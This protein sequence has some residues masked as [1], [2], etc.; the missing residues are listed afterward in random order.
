MEYLD[1]RKNKVSS[2]IKQLF[3]TNKKPYRPASID[4]LRRWR[5]TSLN[6]AGINNF[7]SHSCR[8]ASTPKAKNLNIDMDVI[9]KK[10][11][12]ANVSTFKKFYDKNICDNVNLSMNKILEN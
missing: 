12:W 3:I 11:C 9:L 8:S 10:A 2:S 4:T 7:S 1:R 5:K 6:N